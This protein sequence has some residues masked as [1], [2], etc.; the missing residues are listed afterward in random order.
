MRELKRPRR[1][2]VVRIHQEEYDAL[3]RFYRRVGVERYDAMLQLTKHVKNITDDDFPAEPTAAARL[4]LPPELDE[5][6]KTQAKRL[7]RSYV[8]VLM[9]AV[10]RWEKANTK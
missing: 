2:Q 5:E 1:Y 9:A 10:K 3:Y 4:V 8:R 7:G 6:V